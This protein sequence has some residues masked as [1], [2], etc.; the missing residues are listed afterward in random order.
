M[1]KKVLFGIIISLCLLCGC[2][3]NPSNADDLARDEAYNAGYETGYEEGVQYVLSVL[4]ENADDWQIYMD[5]ED[6][7]ESIRIYY[8]DDPSVDPD[9]VR[10]DILY[11][12]DFE[13]YTLSELLEKLIRESFGE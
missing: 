5:I 1:K 13:H 7:E 3:E 4:R 9:L 10:D 12:P 11:H 2:S 8:Q 6:I